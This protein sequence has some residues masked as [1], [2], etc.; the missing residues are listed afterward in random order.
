MSQFSYMIQFI[1]LISNLIFCLV[2]E[3]DVNELKIKTL[4]T[5]IIH[6][7]I[8]V[9]SRVWCIDNILHLVSVSWRV[10]DV[11]FQI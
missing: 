10:G 2:L 7:E 8:P 9:S 5:F 6:F 4:R 3:M 11:A 1:K